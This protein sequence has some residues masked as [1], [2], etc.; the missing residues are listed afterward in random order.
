MSGEGFS[1]IFQTLTWSIFMAQQLKKPC[2]VKSIFALLLVCFAHF[3]LARIIFALLTWIC[4]KL[5]SYFSHFQGKRGLCNSSSSF[6]IFPWILSSQILL[7]VGLSPFLR[8]GINSNIF[9]LPFLV[10]SLYLQPSAVRETW[11]NICILPNTI[12]L[13]A[14]FKIVRF[15]TAASD[16]KPC[17]P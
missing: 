11:F 13:L 8:T 15:K 5:S 10:P 1:K 6:L 7:W 2:L 14:Y 9:W 4:Y 12:T 3:M 17:P 16:F